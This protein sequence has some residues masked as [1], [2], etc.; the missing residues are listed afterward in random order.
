LDKKAPNLWATDTGS[1]G[2]LQVNKN[3]INLE[4]DLKDEE[5]RYNGFNK[6]IKL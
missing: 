3:E 1:E 2:R 4:L 6:E 5:F